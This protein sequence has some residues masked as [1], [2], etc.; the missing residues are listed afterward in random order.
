M[1]H[2]KRHEISA[3]FT[4]IYYNYDLTLSLYHRT[5]E[6]RSFVRGR[7][8]IFHIVWGFVS[9]SI[10]IECLHNITRTIYLTDWLD[11]LIL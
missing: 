10:S 7:V 11:Q 6:I 1:W 3:N 5:K 4:A 8:V 2:F 9:Q